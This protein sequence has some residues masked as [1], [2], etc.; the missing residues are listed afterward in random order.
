MQMSASPEAAVAHEEYVEKMAL[1]DR[2]LLEELGLT[3]RAA[4][5]MEMH[6]ALSADLWRKLADTIVDAEAA[7]FNE[8]HFMSPADA[9][10]RAGKWVYVTG[11]HVSVNSYHDLDDALDAGIRARAFGPRVIYVGV[12]G[13]LVDLPLKHHR[14]ESS[15][16][17]ML[18]IGVR[19]ATDSRPTLNLGVSNL[20][21]PMLPTVGVFYDT[22]AKD[23]AYVGRA[24][25]SVRESM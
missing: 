25:R 22:G 12:V 3:D 17:L 15:D 9:A 2:L 5:T 23:L 4:L 13:T 1:Y 14:P 24:S 6:D 16:L 11:G 19:A 7:A 18:P 21:S 10:A 8:W 20:L